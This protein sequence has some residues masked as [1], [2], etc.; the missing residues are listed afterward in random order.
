MT[1]HLN[2][3]RAP[4][5]SLIHNLDGRNTVYFLSRYVFQLIFQ[6]LDVKNLR[7]GPL[8]QLVHHLIGVQVEGHHVPPD[9]GDQNLIQNF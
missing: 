7:E 5:S 8:S 4:A 1:L 2:K 9:V 3:R 6:S